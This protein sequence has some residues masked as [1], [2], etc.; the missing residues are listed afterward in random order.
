MKPPGALGDS[1]TRVLLAVIGGHVRHPD[2]RR[3]TG[4]SRSYVHAILDRL[5]AEGLVRWERGRLGTLRATCTRHGEVGSRNLW[6]GQ[7]KYFCG[8]A[9][10]TAREMQERAEKLYREGGA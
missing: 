10:S 6:S 2:I 9:W 3:A 8:A 7:W 4:L 1:A 5:E